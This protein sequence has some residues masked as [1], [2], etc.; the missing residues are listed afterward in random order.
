MIKNKKLFLLFA[1]ILV[2]VLWQFRTKNIEIYNAPG[3]RLEPTYYSSDSIRVKLINNY[4]PTRQQ[5]VMYESQEA[6]PSDIVFF[7]RVVALPDETFEIRDS[8]V[9]I[10]G[11]PLEEPYLNPNNLPNQQIPKQQVSSDSVIVLHDNRQTIPIIVKEIKIDSI[12][13]VEANPGRSKIGNYLYDLFLN[14][15]TKLIPN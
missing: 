1:I 14:V 10:N 12:I 5:I 4:Q 15:G 11:R 9:Y 8:V 6:T 3:S 13:G 7:G 2:I